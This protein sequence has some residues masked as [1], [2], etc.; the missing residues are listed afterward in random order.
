MFPSRF[1]AATTGV[2]PL[3]TVPVYSG[4]GIYEGLKKV[5]SQEEPEF[6]LNEQRKAVFAALNQQTPLIVVLPTGGGKTLI[7]TLLAIL[8]DPGVS[9]VVTLFNALKKDYVR[10]LRLAHIEYI[11]WHHPTSPR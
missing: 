3:A 6:R 8:R 4:E 5:L 11:V 9:I 2:L 7:F 1:E 10:R